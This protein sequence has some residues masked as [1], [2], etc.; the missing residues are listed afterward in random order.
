MAVRGRGTYSQA[1]VFAR[2]AQDKRLRFA[3]R[4]PPLAL[5]LNTLWGE[6]G[7]TFLK[8]GRA[9][10]TKTCEKVSSIP[11]Y[12]HYHASRRHGWETTPAVKTRT[13]PNPLPYPN[14]TTP[15]ACQYSTQAP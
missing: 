14:P 1:I 5:C 13:P 11:K 10:G 7:T 6:P 3:R 9:K 4:L 2:G 12:G 15:S 8:V